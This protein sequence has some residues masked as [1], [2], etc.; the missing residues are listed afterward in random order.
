MTAPV[1]LRRLELAQLKARHDVANQADPLYGTMPDTPRNH[2]SRNRRGRGYS[3][4][5][6]SLCPWPARRRSNPKPQP[7]SPLRPPV[8]T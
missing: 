4:P 3:T 6:N 7:P 5:Q 8:R 1:N 2:Y